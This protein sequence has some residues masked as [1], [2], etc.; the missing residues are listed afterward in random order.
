MTDMSET[1]PNYVPVAEGSMT[2]IK[3]LVSQCEQAGIDVSLD[4][5]REKS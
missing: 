3:E 2:Y 5:C 1:S 4:Q